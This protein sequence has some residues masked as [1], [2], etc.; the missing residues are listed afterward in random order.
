MKHYFGGNMGRL[1]MIIF[2][3][4]A[5]LLTGCGKRPPVEGFEPL[6]ERK[7]EVV[8]KAI[9]LNKQGISSWSELT[10]GIERSLA[11]VSRKKAG[12]AA[13]HQYGLTVT[14]GELRAS[15]LLMRNLLPKLDANPELLAEHFQFLRLAPGPKFT[16]YFEP[17]IE[18]SLTPTA[19]Y[20]YPIYALPDDLRTLRLGQFHPRWKGQRLTY[21]VEDNRITPY[22]D[23][24]E[25]DTNGALKN[26][27]L[28]IAWAKDPI[29]I[30]F[31]Q[32]QG[33]G[34]LIL[35][36][37]T[38]KHI[39]YA[40][41]NGRRYV[42]LGRVM[43]ERGLLEPHN[44]SMQ[45]IRKW[46]DRNPHKT[47]ELLDTNPSYVFFRLS[48]TGP[49]GSINQPLTARVSLATDPNYLPSG[50]LLAFSVPM[51]EKDE[52]GVF[53][54][55]ETLTGFGLAQDKGGAIKKHRIDFFSGYGEEAAW[56][57]GHLNSP[58]EAYLL[59]PRN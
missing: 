32:I 25:I 37:G 53:R 43:K 56:I 14:W 20:A 10:P 21:R 27:Q 34:R 11:F 48:N 51:P 1:C 18:A 7:A 5:L 41:K 47:R 2:C 19:E 39:L 17:A 35:E 54:V 4:G 28:E 52:N 42:S 3:L 13:L 44:I 38:E 23:R 16:S 15:L 55:G 24:K 9:T 31:L 50:G 59:L 29:D 30:F 58:G 45:S 57:A 8:A 36:D 40:G 6:T 46:L 49:F 22:F 33:S 26:K 12:D